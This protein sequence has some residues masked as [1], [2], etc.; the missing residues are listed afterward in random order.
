[1]QYQYLYLHSTNSTGYASANLKL[2]SV[3]YSLIKNLPLDFCGS[4]VTP[5]TNNKNECPV[6]GVYHFSIPY[7]LPWDDQDITSWFATGWEGTTNLEV[8]NDTTTDAK[9]LASC[10]FHWKTYV[11]ESQEDGWHTMPS[12]TQATII[13]AAILGAMCLCCFYLTC[14][15][16]AGGRSAHNKELID[17][18]EE[19]T[20]TEVGSDHSGDVVSSFR[21]MGD[22]TCGGGTKSVSRTSRKAFADKIYKS[23]ASM[24]DPDWA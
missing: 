1:V 19:R 16:R 11:T 17:T 10:K 22:M 15:R 5:N 21:R 9:L 24:S 14:C 4:W 18:I 7:K 3:E 12:A 13:L 2:L 23:K 6:D 20:P 8:Y